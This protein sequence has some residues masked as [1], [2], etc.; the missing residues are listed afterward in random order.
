MKNIY[1]IRHAEGYHNLRTNGHNN[2]HIKYPRLTV[3]GIQ[4]CQKTREQL[5]DIKFD[6]IIVSPLRRTLETAQYIFDRNIP[7]L[8][9]EYIREFIYNPCDFRESIEEVIL[10]FPYV[11]FSKICDTD[12]Y[13]KMESNEDIN[14]RIKRFMKFLTESPYHNIAVISHGVFLNKFLLKYNDELRINY[15]KFMDNCECRKGILYNWYQ[16]KPVNNNSNN[17]LL[18]NVELG[19]LSILGKSHWWSSMWRKEYQGDS[20]FKLICKHSGNNLSNDEINF[21]YIE[22]NQFKISDKNKVSNIG[23]WKEEYINEHYFKLAYYQ[24]DYIDKKLLGYISRIDDNKLEISEKK[25][26]GNIWK[27]ELIDL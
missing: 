3:R 22:N 16:I 23:Y 6:I 5:K 21:L 10:H 1:F 20:Y 2:H 13:N 27:N 24:I 17:T 25:D 12:D 14:I 26:S 9:L 15:N 4:Q 18:L 19:E 8:S 7:H 11:D